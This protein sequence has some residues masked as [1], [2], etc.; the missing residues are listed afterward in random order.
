MGTYSHY[1]KM[2]PYQGHARIYGCNLRKFLQNELAP[3]FPHCYKLLPTPKGLET[4]DPYVII[5]FRKNR[6]TGTRQL[7]WCIRGYEQYE[8]YNKTLIY[9]P[10]H[11]VFFTADEPRGQ[12]DC[13]IKL[14]DAGFSNIAI[15]PFLE[16][17][18]VHMD[19]SKHAG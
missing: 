17:Q 19:E 6:L 10:K 8:M 11:P 2:F 4:R 1:V 3:I 5:A 12:S 14:L 13:F 9:I 18:G 15:E 7:L 16:L